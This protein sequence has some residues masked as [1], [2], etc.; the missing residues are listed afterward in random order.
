MYIQN[1]YTQWYCN[2]IAKAK[3]R[4]LPPN[5][6]FE[7]H[8]II[9]K[10]LGGSNSSDNLVQ[11][12]A[13]E[14]RLIHLLLP[15]MTKNPKHTV[16][17]WYA[18]WM[19]LRTKNKSQKRHVSKGKHYEITR[20]KI[21]E[22]S[23]SLHKGKIV[24]TETRKKISDSHKGK[25][26]PNLGKPMS[27]EQKVKMKAT[28]AKNGRFITP[29]TIAKILETRKNYKHSEATKIKI[30][31]NNLGKHNTPCSNERKE[32]YSNLYSGRPAPWRKGVAPANKGKTTSPETILKQKES[33]K[34]RAIFKCIH[35]GKEVTKANLSRWHNDKCKTKI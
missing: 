10:S 17:M 29:E 32:Y 24:S 35:C 2:I 34:N 22:F 26:G 33:H 31:E 12:L 9:P 28:I 14:H 15:R 3:A 21:A 4:T 7:T 20:A 1:K 5:I 6:Y 16:S 30:S 8:H 19:I 23:S 11:L 13:Q 18:A 25:P 27:E